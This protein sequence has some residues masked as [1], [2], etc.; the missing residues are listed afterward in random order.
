MHVKA[1]VTYSWNACNSPDNS[2][3]AA[4]GYKVKEIN[5]RRI[6]LS[7]CIIKYVKYCLPQHVLGASISGI[8]AI[9]T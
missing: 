8:K 3:R 1:S 9:G 4:L 6:L 7:L 2:M 5:F